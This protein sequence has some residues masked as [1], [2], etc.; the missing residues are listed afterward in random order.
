M[1]GNQ[2]REQTGKSN[3]RWFLDN[4][5][6]R[7][8]YRTSRV[9]AGC[10]VVRSFVKNANDRIRFHIS[11]NCPETID[12]MKRYKYPEKDGIIQNENPEKLDDD[13]VDM[14]RYYFMYRV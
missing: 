1:S 2:E 4:T 9:N 12:G 6:I 3:V 13:A 5:G 11:S 7:F 10:A 14:I 8:K